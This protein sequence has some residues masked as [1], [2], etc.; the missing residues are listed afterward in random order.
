MRCWC[1][2]HFEDLT[3]VEAATLLGISQNAA[4]N[5]YVRALKRFREALAPFPGLLARTLRLQICQLNP[6]GSNRNLIEKLAE[7]FMQRRRAGDIPTI[8]DYAKKY[9]DIAEEIRE[10]FPA[11]LVMEDVRGDMSSSSTC[12]LETIADQGY[13]GQTIGDYRISREIGRG[14]MGIVYEAN[15][16]SLGRRVALKVLSP[17]LVRSP[18]V[19]ATIPT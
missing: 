4:S 16:E 12:H 6:E 14:G 10:L 15:Q 11:L 8:D 13:V 3:N 7:E 5:R 2:R 17:E 1:L 9:P 19:P 18:K